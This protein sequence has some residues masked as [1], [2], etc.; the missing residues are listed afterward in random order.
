MLLH[1]CHISNAKNVLGLSYL[2]LQKYDTMKHH[3]FVNS[4]FP[5][6]PWHYIFLVFSYLFLSLLCIF[7]S[8]SS[9]HYIPDFLKTCPRWSP[10]F[11]LQRR[12]EKSKGRTTGDQK[13][14]V[15]EVGGNLNT[16]RWVGKWAEKISKIKLRHMTHKYRRL[17][18][19]GRNINQH[20]PVQRD[21][22]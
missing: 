3:C 12:R 11:H 16:K 7:P 9:S 14:W 4:F 1:D 18:K 21:R 17:M 15:R 22:H 5:W 2:I 8:L 20:A 13:G 19:T 10:H 6:L